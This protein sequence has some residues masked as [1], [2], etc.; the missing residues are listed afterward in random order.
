M[1]AGCRGLIQLWKDEEE[2]R[3]VLSGS[4]EASH[5]HQS[6]KVTGR[7]NSGSM[8]CWTRKM[9]Q[10]LRKGKRAR[11]HKRDATNWLIKPN[12]QVLEPKYGYFH[13]KN[14]KTRVLT[15]G[16]ILEQSLFQTTLLEILSEF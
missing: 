15:C 11:K 10:V 13:C 9:M 7:R 3:K 14:C 8:M 6:Q 5:H 2:M 1:V 4:V 12:L 16:E